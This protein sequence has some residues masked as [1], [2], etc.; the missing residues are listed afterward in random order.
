M[1]NSQTSPQ[2]NQSQ[3][4][5]RVRDILFGP[6]LRDYEQRFEAVH[7]DLERLQDEIDHLTDQLR[8][9]GADH[10]KQQQKLHREMRQGDDQLRAELRQAAQQLMTE[11]VDRVDLGQLFIE[12][13]THLKKG[14]PIADVLKDLQAIE[15][16]NNKDQE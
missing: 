13:G 1:A 14:V 8:T 16:G 5:D 10:Q 9:Q 3:E 2:G 7:R 11:K 4:V 15:L 12:L 6:Q